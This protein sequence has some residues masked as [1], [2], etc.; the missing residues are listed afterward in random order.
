MASGPGGTHITQI[1]QPALD[2]FAVVAL[3]K[4]RGGGAGGGG[5][6]CGITECNGEDL[7]EAGYPPAH[8]R[9]QVTSISFGIVSE[10]QYAEGMMTLFREV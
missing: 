3:T 5:G 1:N 6:Y 9:R 10:G 4:T 7:G 8:F 2:T